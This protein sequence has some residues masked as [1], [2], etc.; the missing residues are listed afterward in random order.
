[1]PFSLDVVVTE[2]RYPGPD[3]D[4]S[5]Y[6]FEQPSDPANP[7]WTRRKILTEYSLNNLDVADLDRD[8]DPDIVICEHKGPA[9]RLQ[10]RE[11][12]GK[13]RFACMS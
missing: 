7:N 12:N 11:N 4:G 10:I 13:G 3:P 5:I 8:G 1:V 2:E 9:E 6:W